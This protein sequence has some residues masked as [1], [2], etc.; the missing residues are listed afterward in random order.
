[1][2]QTSEERERLPG[3][4]RS[5]RRVKQ[6]QNEQVADDDDS[7]YHFCVALGRRGFMTHQSDHSYKQK[8]FAQA[9][10][11]PE[12]RDEMVQRSATR[13]KAAKGDQTSEQAG[14]Q[15]NSTRNSKNELSAQSQQ[16][17]QSNAQF[18]LARE[19]G[20]LPCN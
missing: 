7:G 14:V 13:S 10:K 12:Q 17:Q 5:T 20:R 15:H 8:D 16:G 9:M 4:E 11:N 19:G 3:P 2:K 6:Q 1:M 18:W